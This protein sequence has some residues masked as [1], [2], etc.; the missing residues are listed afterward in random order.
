MGAGTSGVVTFLKVGGVVLAPPNMMVLPH[1]VL[2]MVNVE[3]V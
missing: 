3:L 1:T 2:A